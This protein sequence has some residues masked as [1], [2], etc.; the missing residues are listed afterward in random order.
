MAACSATVRGS[1]LASTIPCQ[2]RA[3]RVWLQGLSGEPDEDGGQGGVA[4]GSC[5]A[6]VEVAVV[7]HQRGVALRCPHQDQM[8]PDFRQLAGVCRLRGK[9]RQLLLDDPAGLDEFQ[10]GVLPH[11][12]HRHRRCS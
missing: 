10:D 2:T 5:D 8:L 4:T 7:P 3:R 9:R 11:E 1:A 12:L 6:G